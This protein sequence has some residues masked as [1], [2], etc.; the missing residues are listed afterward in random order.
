MTPDGVIQLIHDTLRP[1]YLMLGGF[2]VLVI[3]YL[4]ILI[5]LKRR[6]DFKLLSDK[7]TI[8]DLQVLNPS[9]FESYISQLFRSMGYKTRTV[10][11]VSDGGIDVIAEKDG[12]THYIQCKKFINRKVDVG[13]VR[14]FY[15]A[16]ADKV[17]RGKGYFITTNVFTLDA[18]RFAES[19]PI[20]LIDR[21]KLM[22]YI[23]KNNLK[24]SGA[25]KEAIL[26]PK[27][28]GTLSQKSG[29]FGNFMGCSNYPKC[30]YTKNI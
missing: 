29:K 30:R 11:G 25:S 8:K 1:I 16:I 14:D 18:E 12:F 4:I 6:R 13:A 28:D 15:G 7:K 22:E 9:E 19:K 3:I 17:D 24:L 5:I 23:G 10:G 27:C 20:E 2:F 26:C 21:F